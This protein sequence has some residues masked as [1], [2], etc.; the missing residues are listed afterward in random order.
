L[1]PNFS[2]GGLPGL[3]INDHDRFDRK[4]LCDFLDNANT[5]M[6][7]CG[8]P[9][10]STTLRRLKGIATVAL[11]DSG[12]RKSPKSFALA[13]C[14]SPARNNV[15]ALREP[16]PMPDMKKTERPQKTARRKRR[17]PYITKPNTPQ[18]TQIAI[19]ALALTGSNNSE[20]ARQVGRPRDCGAH[21][22]DVRDGGLPRS[23][24]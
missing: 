19:E 16:S 2:Q 20:I 7:K 10:S 22:H 24:T 14:Y 6:T 4:L 23:S 5:S 12:L 8:T 13:S 11:L 9:Y 18:S 17:A 21:P 15:F 3:N 1:A